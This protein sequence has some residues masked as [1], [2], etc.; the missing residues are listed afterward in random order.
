M[1]RGEK[2]KALLDNL[3]RSEENTWEGYVKRCIRCSVLGVTVLL[4][5]CLF[6]SHDI[7][8]LH[9]H[10]IQLILLAGV[11]SF[12]IGYGGLIITKY[13]RRKE[14]KLNER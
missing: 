2:E 13:I 7:L 9:N 14:K 12:M 4:V 3:S 5:T 8:H 11:L 6:N 10:M 1:S